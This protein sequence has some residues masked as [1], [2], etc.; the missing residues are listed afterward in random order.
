MH[1]SETTNKEPLQIL[2]DWVEDM[3][4]SIFALSA[5]ENELKMLSQFKDKINSLKN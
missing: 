4:N 1:T 3:E 5:P 2:I